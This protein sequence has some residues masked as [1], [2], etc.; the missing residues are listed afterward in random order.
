MPTLRVEVKHRKNSR[1][2][3]SGCD[4][5]RPGYDRLAQRSWEFVPLRQIPVLLAYAMRR[6]NSCVTGTPARCAVAWSR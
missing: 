5:V 3:C 4:E 2:T 1:P 6:I